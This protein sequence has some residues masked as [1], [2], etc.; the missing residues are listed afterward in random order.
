MQE[1]AG[2][3]HHLPGGAAVFA[4]PVVTEIAALI[5]LVDSLAGPARILSPRHEAMWRMLTMN[6][7]RAGRDA[8]PDWGAASLGFQ[9]EIDS[10][11][12]AKA[13]GMKTD[14]LRKYLRSGI[15]QG[16]KVGAKWRVPLSSIEDYRYRKAV[17]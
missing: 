8:Q 14:T 4:T 3:V 11:T 13:L 10:E 12:A 6:D 7:R 17:A 2:Q 16:H 15:I 9:H 1:L 5:V